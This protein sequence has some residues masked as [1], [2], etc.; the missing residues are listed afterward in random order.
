MFPLLDFVY[1]NCLFRQFKVNDLLFIEYKCVAEES[2]C[3]IW[4][5]HNYFVYVLTG[6]K[7]WQTPRASYELTAGQGIFVKRG[8]NVVHQFFDNDFCALIIFVPDDFLRDVVSGCM[9]SPSH[10]DDTPPTDS[11]VRLAIN[12]VLSAYFQSVFVYFQEDCDPPVPLLE[13]KFRELVM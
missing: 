10:G 13:M 7:I 4:S 2:V 6:K 3:K 11:V 9:V 1:E 12:P 8:A 5:Q